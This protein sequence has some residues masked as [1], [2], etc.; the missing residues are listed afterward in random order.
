MKKPKKFIFIQDYGT[1]RNEILVMSGIT[2]KQ[3]VFKFLKKNRVIPAISKWILTDF[4]EWK[5]AIEKKQKGL[6]C[7]NEDCNGTVLFL[8]SPEDSWDYWE[9]LM[10]EC[11]HIVQQM[12]SEKMMLKEMDAQAYLFEYLF[13]NIRRKLAGYDRY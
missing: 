1:Y 11:H 2:D 3:E 4:N 8:R 6:F 13:H 5:E 10:H 12:C 9:V 7:W